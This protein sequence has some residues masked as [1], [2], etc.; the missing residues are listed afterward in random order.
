M[1][2]HTGD[3]CLYGAIQEQMDAL[4]ARG[5]DYEVVP[6]V[7]SFCGAAAALRQEYTL[8]GISQSVVITRL[9]GRTPM[10]AGEGMRT[11]AESGSTMVIFL[12]SGMLAELSAELLAAGRSSDEPA[13][14]VYKATWPEERVVRCTVGT[15]AD[16]GAREGIDRTALVVVG[17]VLGARGGLAHNGAQAGSYERS[18]LYDPSFA[19]GYRKASS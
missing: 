12:S 7:S 14:L 17:R 19:T 11:M 13:A 3:P 4:D 16:A 1:R 2:L 9:S 10:P 8:P 5:V 6:G 15:L 18:K